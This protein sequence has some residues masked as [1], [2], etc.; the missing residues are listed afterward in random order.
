M[1]KSSSAHR[2]KSGGQKGRDGKAPPPFAAKLSSGK[3]RFGVLVAFL[4]LVAI[5]GGGSRADI[6]SL[7]ILRPF[8]IM[9]CVYGLC[10]LNRDQARRVRA[11]LIII[12][13]LMAIAVLQLIPLP[14]S[15]W[16]NIPGRE[17]IRA[18]S[19]ALGVPY[20]SRP[21]SMDPNRT[22]NTFFALFVPLTA[23]LLVTIQHNEKHQ[24]V[25]RVLI[26]IGAASALMGIFQMLGVDA[27]YLY[28][29][30]NYETPVGLF[31]NRNHNAVLLSWLIAATTIFQLRYSKVAA[32]GYRIGLVALIG[33]VLLAL[34]ILTGSRA[35]I[36]AAALSIAF[37]LWAAY[38]SGWYQKAFPARMQRPWLFFAAS[39]AIVALPLMALLASLLSSNRVTAF[40][41]LMN[42]DGTS[43]LRSEFLPIYLEMVRDYFPF[44]SGFGSFEAVFRAYEPADMLTTRYLNQAHN[45]LLQLIIEG[46]LPALMLLSFAAFWLVSKTVAVLRAQRD[47]SRNFRL[48]LFFSIALWLLG[49]LVDY[50]LRTPLASALV[51]CL[52]G[53]FALATAKE[54]RTQPVRRGD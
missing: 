24:S 8:S 26:L 44:G 15:I 45:D 3:T 17:L 18:T 36:V 51:A 23:L 49:S 52:T 32:F 28:R 25:L 29:L 53:L 20:G 27:L 34:V 30:T 10:V 41:R 16:T 48:F 1:Q 43:E 42:R 38:S 31:A 14:A 11:P 13:G 19:E 21:I 47:F 7:I 40:S 50:P 54:A 12:V 2:S 9:F 22:W 35:G 5:M 39:A 4:V 37:S 6:Q 33:L 46:G